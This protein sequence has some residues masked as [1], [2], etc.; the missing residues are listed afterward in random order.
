MKDTTRN[1]RTMSQAESAERDRVLKNVRQLAQRFAQDVAKRP[2]LLVSVAS[3]NPNVYIE[4]TYQRRR[5]WFFS[6]NEPEFIQ[7]AR[8]VVQI[9]DVPA[10]YITVDGEP[11]GQLAQEF[12]QGQLYVIDA[13]GFHV[14]TLVSLEKELQTLCRGLFPS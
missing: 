1:M 7:C 5:F 9:L 14:D 3:H 12:E 6:Y 2:D 8:A 4:K 13:D 10:I 11:T